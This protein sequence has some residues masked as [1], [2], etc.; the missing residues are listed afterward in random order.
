M[1]KLKFK[2]QYLNKLHIKIQIESLNSLIELI[3]FGLDKKKE[4]ALENIDAQRCQL[5]DEI[6]LNELQ[7]QRSIYEYEYINTFE[8]EFHCSQ[9]ENLSAYSIITSCYML[10]ETNLT[11]FANI[12]KKHYFLGLKYNDLAGGKTEKIKTYLS[13]LA[14]ID[15][16]K[17]DY[18]AQLKDLEVIRNC[19]IHN[20]GKVNHE[21][22]D[23]KKIKSIVH[24]YSD[25]I[26]VN[27]PIYADEDYLIIKFSLCNHFL[28]ILNSFFDELVNLFG[29]NQ[30]FCVGAAATQQ[31]EKERKHA[32]NELDCSIEKANEIYNNRMKSL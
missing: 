13:K 10:F 26:S 9:F 23:S 29:F 11:A 20:E 15:I 16:A 1:T 12:A 21:F 32:K 28:E 19:I 24:K 30:N 5:K 17:N 18:W 6:D 3:Q 22:K 4:E 25:H 7:I 27:K 8:G 2:S 31:I 14:N